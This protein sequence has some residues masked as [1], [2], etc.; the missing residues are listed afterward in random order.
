MKIKLLQLKREYDSV[1][2]SSDGC[3]TQNHWI[4]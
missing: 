2:K 4:L 3:E 1:P